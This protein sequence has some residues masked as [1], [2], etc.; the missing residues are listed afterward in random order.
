MCNPT[1]QDN[2]DQSIRQVTKKLPKWQVLKVGMT[3]FQLFYE[4]KLKTLKSWHFEASK[5][6][7]TKFKSQGLHI[8]RIKH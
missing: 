8:I 7:M 1:L 6:I 5:D 4:M 2:Q 3:V